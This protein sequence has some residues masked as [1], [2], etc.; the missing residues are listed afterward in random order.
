MVLHFYRDL[1]PADIAELLEIP[2]G[3]VSSRLHYGTRALRAA[4]DAD[5]RA[6][7]DAGER[8]A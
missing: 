7:L 8:S 4:L 6:T 2:V 5:E 3:T 1:A